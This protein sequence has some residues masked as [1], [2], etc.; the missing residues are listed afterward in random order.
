MALESVEV[1]HRRWPQDRRPYR[2]FGCPEDGVVI[3]VA[4]FE[5]FDELAKRLDAQAAR[6][7]LVERRQ[8]LAVEGRVV[9][10]PRVGRDSP[11]AGTLEVQPPLRGIRAVEGARQAPR[12][13]DRCIPLADV[14]DL[15]MAA[16]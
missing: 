16:V 6:Q 8:R 11:A 14:G 1:A 3:V 13:T 12:S 5:S 4:R 7:V 2:E 9:G 15:R 10:E